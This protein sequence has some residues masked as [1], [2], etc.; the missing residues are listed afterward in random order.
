MAMPSNRG[1]NGHLAMEESTRAR[2]GVCPTHGA[3]TPLIVGNRWKC[4]FC[5]VF[6]RKQESMVEAA[7]GE[8][9]GR[10]VDEIFW[11]LE[12]HRM[13]EAIG[14][15]L[16]ALPEEVQ[17]LVDYRT[18]MDWIEW[19]D[20]VHMTLPAKELDKAVQRIR[21]VATKLIRTPQL[22]LDL[23]G[24]ESELSRR[25]EQRVRLRREQEAL[26]ESVHELEGRE[27]KLHDTLW[28][29]EASAHMSSEEIVQRVR[30]FS[31]TRRETERLI[32]VNVRVNRENWSAQY[33]LA[34]L[35]G[36][37]QRVTAALQRLQ[38][39]ERAGWETLADKLTTKDLMNLIDLREKNR[40]KEL[41]RREQ[42]TLSSLNNRVA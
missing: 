28:S 33:H 5:G 41:L 40:L 13:L 36:E 9:A 19:T 26:T 10:T 18:A 8:N 21:Q 23:A 42:A 6:I 31:E 15:N 35:Q 12:V 1:E 32:D 17:A 37:I 29:V 39:L 34:G 24:L 14:D 7:S 16:R 11:R 38:Q 30:Q 4:P 27:K 2:V 20:A 3:V 25:M 22:F